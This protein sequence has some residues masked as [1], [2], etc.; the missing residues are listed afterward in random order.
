MA[1]DDD[2]RLFLKQLR[3]K[4]VRQENSPAPDVCAN[5][6]VAIG[7]IVVAANEGHRRDRAQRL[8][9]VL[10]ADVS[11]V[12]NCVD[13]LQRRERFGADQAVRVGNDADAATP[14]WTLSW[15]R[16]SFDSDP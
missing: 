5:N 1:E 3:T 4:D 13:A 6:F 12:K 10:A 14:R 15:P 7:V 16:S 11:S 8:E 2:I 9:N